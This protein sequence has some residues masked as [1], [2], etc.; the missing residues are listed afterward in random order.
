MNIAKKD[1]PKLV[2]DYIHT[3]YKISKMKEEGAPVHVY[4]QTVNHYSKLKELAEKIE[5]DGFFS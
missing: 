2:T 3:L 1:F 4:L 5:K